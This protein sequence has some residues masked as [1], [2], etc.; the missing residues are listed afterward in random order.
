MAKLPQRATIPSHRLTALIGFAQI[1]GPPP[2]TPNPD[3]HTVTVTLRPLILL[4]AFGLA[5]VTAK[6][7]S[8]QGQAPGTWIQIEAKP[9][10]AEAADRARAWEALFGQVAGF[11][12]DTGWFVLALGPFAAEVAEARL[13]ALKAENLIPGDSF[14][15]DGT[16]YVA[17]FWPEDSLMQPQVAMPEITAPEPEPETP[18][19]LVTAPAEDLETP[20]QARLSEAAL[21][22]AE[23]ET[24][25]AALMWFG[26]YDSTIDGAFGRGTRA[27]MAAWQEANGFAATGV[28]STVQR[29]VLTEAYAADQATFGLVPVTEA[30]AGIEITLPLGLV[31]FDRYE[32]PFAHFRPREGGE[33]RI[34][35]ISQPGDATTL[36][37]L[38]DTLQSLSIL[39]PQGERRLTDTA[40]DIRGENQGLMTQAFAEA[41]RGVIKGWI[42]TW[43]PE[44]GPEMERVLPI[45]R[46]SFRSLGDRALDP[47]IVPLT[48]AARSGLLSGFDLRRPRLSR[49]GLFIDAAG[50]VLTTQAATDSCARITLD[51]E[52][53]ARVVLVDAGTGLALLA[54]I[55]PIAPA[56]FARFK[57]GTLRVGDEVAVSGYSYEDALPAPVLTF[58]TL[59][60][61]TGLDGEEGLTRLALTA[62][63]GDE[64]G[65]VLDSAGA[66]AGVLLPAPG[67]TTR[68]L[69]EGV[70][71]AAP[72]PTIAKALAAS[73]VPLT[74]A[75]DTAPLPADDMAALSD[76]VTV[77]VSCWD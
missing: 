49:S 61:T 31:E 3:D 5:L 36:A 24:L 57:A 72:V 54:P 47:G 14:L 22:L 68:R 10:R 33:T 42:V 73:G 20:E 58:G 46:S 75:T 35:L 39:P 60:A 9:T 30:E 44:T 56:Q 65:P 15:A 63:P 27:S 8:A 77:L 11:Q 17:A 43:N 19:P 21:T 4:I 12:A 1:G 71:F 66:V 34:S 16:G 62:L 41:S 23:R 53:E 40:I 50:H 26:F 70:A 76:A 25:Q 64:G 52:T 2:P 32:P 37:T 74:T 69:P 18:A 59:A 55:T 29:T 38:F 45:L 28:L 7:V 13:A 51:L 6:P 48:E 67:D